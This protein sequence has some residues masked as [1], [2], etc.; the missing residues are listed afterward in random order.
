MDIICLHLLQSNLIVKILQIRAVLKEG[1]DLTIIGHAAAIYWVLEYL[2][3]NASVF[4]NVIDLKT[5]QPLD[6]ETI[7]VSIRK[8]GKVIRVQED[9]LFGGISS[10]ISALI[11][12]NC[13]EFLDAPVKRVASLETPILFEPNLEK[14]YLG[15]LG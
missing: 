7:Y 8:T 15:K 1:K 10:A 9:S 6:T 5:L 3:N 2:E 13:F 14:Q 4:T 12:E 11:H